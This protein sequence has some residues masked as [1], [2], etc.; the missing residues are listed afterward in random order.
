MI[1]PVASGCGPSLAQR[2]QPVAGPSPCTGGQASGERE[3]RRGLQHARHPVRDLCRAHA[4]DAAS[5]VGIVGQPFAGEQRECGILQPAPR[6][7]VRAQPSQ[8][9]L[10]ACPLEILRAQSARVPA[11]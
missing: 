8:Q 5:P 4:G 3:G 9:H 7:L 10:V 1:T 6:P 11:Q 2:A